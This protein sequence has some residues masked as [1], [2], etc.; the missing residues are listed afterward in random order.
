M[1]DAITFELD[2][3]AS[4]SLHVISKK[5]KKIVFEN[6]YEYNFCIL[7]LYCRSVFIKVQVDVFII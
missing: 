1:V 4:F 6:A 2:V 5:F 3:I 7:V